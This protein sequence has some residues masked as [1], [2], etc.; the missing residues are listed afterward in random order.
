MPQLAYKCNSFTTS[1]AATERPECG[2]LVT[3]NHIKYHIIGVDHHTVHLELYAFPPTLPL[4]LMM[5]HHL[6]ECQYQQWYDSLDD[7][8]H[9]TLHT[10]FVLGAIR[11]V[12]TQLD[13]Y[14]A[15]CDCGTLVYYYQGAWH[16]VNNE[17]QATAKAA[18]IAELLNYWAEAA[19]HVRYDE[20]VE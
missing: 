20:P 14:Q 7:R 19:E 11:S 3:I 15:T 12:K 1:N 6:D 10:K 17:L 4:Y 5:L 16:A 8:Q 13:W 18:T 9:T 2:D